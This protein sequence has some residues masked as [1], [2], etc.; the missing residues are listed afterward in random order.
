MLTQKALPAHRCA[1]PCAAAQDAG[2]AVE[3]DADAAAELGQRFP[4]QFASV[5][6]VLPA[7]ASTQYLSSCLI[8]G[9]I[10][11]LDHVTFNHQLIAWICAMIACQRLP[12]VP[13][14]FASRLA[15]KLERPA[16]LV[17]RWPERACSKR[18]A[19]WH[20]LHCLRRLMKL[21]QP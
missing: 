16:C 18:S 6:Q 2:E 4:S 3:G 20:V 17:A 13:C 12:L 5:L 1:P 15:S 7:S 21:C 19:R 11:S 9:L 10:R 8:C 14:I